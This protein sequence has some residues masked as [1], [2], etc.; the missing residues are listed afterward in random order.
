MR[1]RIRHETSYTFDP[2][3]KFV[4][5]ILRMTPR[6]HEGQHIADWRMDVDVDCRLKASEDTF[7]N[8]THTFS[9]DGPIQRLTILAEGEVETFD[10]AGVVRGSI[11]RFP[12]ELYLRDTPLTTAD[13]ALR[14]FA[15]DVAKDADGR[16]DTLHRLMTAVHEGLKADPA[17]DGGEMRAA[18]DVFKTGGGAA[19]DFCHVFVAAARHLEIPAR[20]VAGYCL[21]DPTVSE[22][23]TGHCW[24]EAFVE[25]LGWIGF[26]A[27]HDVCPQECHVRVSV[28]L[29]RL[30]A[31][32]VRNSFSASDKIRTDVRCRVM[33]GLLQSQR[34]AQSQL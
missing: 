21:P 10:M 27:V 30:G 31:A 19:R 23:A 18:D 20:V 15:A 9:C 3:R 25:G 13:T 28:G 7:G 17:A 8:I 6:N 1:V 26:D 32:P 33:T 11:E 34:Q 29:D 12:A 24:S 14:A 4:T 22:T 2:A 5:Q 16:L